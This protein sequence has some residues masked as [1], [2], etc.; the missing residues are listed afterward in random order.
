MGLQEATSQT[1]EGRTALYPKASVSQC[2][3]FRGRACTWLGQK[4]ESLTRQ[5]KGWLRSTQQK[6]TRVSAP[7]YNQWPAMEPCPRAPGIQV[8]PPS[9]ALAPA[10]LGRPNPST[11]S[12]S[13]ASARCSSSPALAVAGLTA[14]AC[15]ARRRSRQV[16]QGTVAKRPG[17]AETPDNA[18][19]EWL[20][21][22]ELPT[23]LK[24]VLGSS[25]WASF[26]ASLVQMFVVAGL[27]GLGTFIEQGESP[28]FYAQ[29]Y[30]D[31]SGVILALGFDHM[32]SCPLFLGLLAWLA[33][34]LVACTATTQLPLA[35]GHDTKQYKEHPLLHIRNAKDIFLLPG[36]HHLVISTPIWSPTYYSP[37][38]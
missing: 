25:A 12:V 32:Y 27:S 19:E 30:P 11:G 4:P 5:T 29:N 8:R 17:D 38:I 14:T 33:A 18:I 34:S 31:T 21:S 20:L 22:L 16:L 28:A 26:A 10:A 9:A 36:K 6:T 23:P 2:V 35:T 3:R 37:Q 13:S 15:L 1:D 7:R 24:P